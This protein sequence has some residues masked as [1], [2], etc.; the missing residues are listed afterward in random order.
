MFS[1]TPR[2]LLY[3]LRLIRKSK[4]YR[5]A[6]LVVYIFR[7]ATLRRGCYSFLLYVEISQRSLLYRKLIVGTR[8]LINEKSIF[9]NFC[10]LWTDAHGAIS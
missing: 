9:F 2:A 7:L 8:Q 4:N 10:T 3:L 1:S 5:Y 6:R